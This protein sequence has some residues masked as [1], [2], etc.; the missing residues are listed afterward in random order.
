M[1]ACRLAVLST[2]AKVAGA[3]PRGESE[4]LLSALP[5]VRLGTSRPSQKPNY[6]APRRWGLQEEGA[7][8]VL[9]DG[10]EMRCGSK[11]PPVKWLLKK[12][13][14]HPGG[15]GSVIRASVHRLESH[16][17]DSLVWA[18]WEATT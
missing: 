10:V 16:G 15:F 3:E 6:Q 11:N 18:L 4:V 1:A 9:S 2:Q 14:F 12:G 7:K 5:R 8:E 13:V 17:F